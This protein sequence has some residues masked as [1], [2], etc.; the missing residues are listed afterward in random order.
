MAVSVGVC[1]PPSFLVIRTLS[2]FFFILF[3]TRQMAVFS[4]FFVWWIF[5]YF[6]VQHYL[7]GHVWSSFLFF[8]V[9]DIIYH[10][11]QRISPSQS[12]YYWPFV[13]FRFFVLDFLYDDFWFC[14]TCLIYHIFA[15]FTCGQ[16]SCQLFGFAL[17]YIFSVFFNVVF[18]IR[19][20]LSIF[21]DISKFSWIQKF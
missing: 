2:G 8:K 17:N 10:R 4:P 7:S 11:W 14:I 13:R 16:L 3:N 12:S 21:D 5:I 9:F 19:F 18:S 1:L 20:S 6:G 15:T